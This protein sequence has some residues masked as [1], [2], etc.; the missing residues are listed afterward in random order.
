LTQK[1]HKPSE[2]M[3]KVRTTCFR[4]EKLCT[5]RNKVFIVFSERMTIMSFKSTEKQIF[6]KIANYFFCHLRALALNTENSMKIGNLVCPSIN[7]YASENTRTFLRPQ[8]MKA[9]LYPVLLNNRN[10]TALEVLRLRPLVLLSAK[11]TLNVL[12]R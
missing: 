11:T 10:S 5:F 1:T 12:H 3:V 6:V 4:I 8:I 2:Y 7:E 9:N